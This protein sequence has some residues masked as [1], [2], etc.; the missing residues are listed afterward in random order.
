[1]PP[2]DFEYL[3]AQPSPI[4]TIGLRRRRRPAAPD[5][6]VTEITLEHELLMSS[7]NTASERA[8]AS[9]SV[10]MHGGTALRV[11]VGGLGLGYTAHAALASSDVAR[12]EVVEFL[13]PVIRWVEQGLVPLS[14]ALAAD[15]RLHVREGDVYGLLWQPPEQTWDLLL[16]DVD[17]SPDEPLGEQSDAFYTEEGLRRARAHLAPGGVLAT[18]SYADCPPFA[19]VLA[20]VFAEV[21]VEP[22]TFLDP[23][24]HEEATHWLFLA[25]G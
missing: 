20:R 12:V 2:I 19:A 8:L 16:I 9:R 17:H 25:R 3:D 14:E 7:L 24:F 6:L 22:V 13:P 10:A 23:A 11:L 15:A 5:E 4:G 1:M 18:W 21:Q